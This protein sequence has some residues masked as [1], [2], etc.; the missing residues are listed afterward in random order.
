MGTTTPGIVVSSVNKEEHGIP[1]FKVQ[2]SE[3]YHF[4][5]LHFS[6]IKT[7]TKKNSAK[8]GLKLYFKLIY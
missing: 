4:P 3:Q 6:K 1:G 8:F 2:G 5:T 7:A